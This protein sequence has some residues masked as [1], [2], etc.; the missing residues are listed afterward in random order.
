MIVST[1]YDPIYRRLVDDKLNSNHEN[2][3]I[4]CVTNYQKVV[5]TVDGVMH[6]FHLSTPLAMNLI[7]ASITIWQSARSRRRTRVMLFFPKDRWSATPATQSYPYRPYRH[8][9]TQRSLF[10]SSR[11]FWLLEVK[12]AISDLSCWISDL[13]CT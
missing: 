8:S 6:L 13:F 9:H 5:Q 3:R 10:D 11:C 1:I 4:W 7:S 12:Q 2:N